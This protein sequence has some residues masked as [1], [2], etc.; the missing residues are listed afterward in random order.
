[1]LC[2]SLLIR[3]QPVVNSEAVFLGQERGLI[4]KVMHHP[5]GDY[6]D[7]NGHE[8]FQDEDPGPASLASNAMHLSDGGGEK[9]SK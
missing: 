5:D 8:A 3:L 9:T 6:P 2:A 4:G 7:D 1:M